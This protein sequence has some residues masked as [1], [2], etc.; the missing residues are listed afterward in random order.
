MTNF[1]DTEKWVIIV[2]SWVGAILVTAVL[3]GIAYRRITRRWAAGS[4]KVTS[5]ACAFKYIYIYHGCLSPQRPTHP[6]LCTA[7]ARGSFALAPVK[8]GSSAARVFFILL[9]L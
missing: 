2:A 6:I 5:R 9:C 3:C 7:P 4:S 8:G 1:T